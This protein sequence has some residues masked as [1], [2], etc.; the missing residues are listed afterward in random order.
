MLGKAL[1]WLGLHDWN[2]NGHVPYECVRCKKEP[3]HER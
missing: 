1:C 3:T 2:W